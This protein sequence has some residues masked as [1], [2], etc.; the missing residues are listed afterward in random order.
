MN[1]QQPNHNTFADQVVVPLS[2]EKLLVTDPARFFLLQESDAIS[3]AQK[4]YMAELLESADAK[5]T[6]HRCHETRTR[7]CGAVATRLII[8]FQGDFSFVTAPRLVCDADNCLD[9]VVKRTKFTCDV[10]KFPCSGI[11]E[12]IK[13]HNDPEGAKIFM[14]LLAKSWGVLTPPCHFNDD[15]LIPFFGVEQS[16][17][18]SVG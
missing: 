7:G 18:T 12:Y 11:E 5:P 8:A 4:Q 16:S 1:N 17:R 15:A 2:F 3:E 9:Q 10:F 13:K 14:K 6:S